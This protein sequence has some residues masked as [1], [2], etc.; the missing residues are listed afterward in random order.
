VSDVGGACG[1]S[2]TRS[3]QLGDGVVTD[4]RVYVTGQGSGAASDIRVGHLWVLRAGRVVRWVVYRRLEEALE[5][6]G[7]RE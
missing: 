6:V 2:T 7:L 4:V 5:A 1:G 3:S